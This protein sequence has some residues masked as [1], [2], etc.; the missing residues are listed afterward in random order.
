MGGV[1][2]TSSIIS[3]NNDLPMEVGPMLTMWSA[4]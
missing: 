2:S 4:C 1:I 3:L